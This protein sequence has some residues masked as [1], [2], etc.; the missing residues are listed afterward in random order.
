MSDE[1]LV[2]QIIEDD[3]QE[4]IPNPIANSNNI[5]SNFIKN[6]RKISNEKEKSFIIRILIE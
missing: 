3:D 4:N 2:A 5:I 1:T 6:F